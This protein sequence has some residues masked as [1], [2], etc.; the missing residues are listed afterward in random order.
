MGEFVTVKFG[1]RGKTYTRKDFRDMDDYDLFCKVIVFADCM[2]WKDGDSRTD[3]MNMLCIASSCI[4]ER[5]NPKANEEAETT[6]LDDDRQRVLA[7]ILAEQAYLD[8]EKAVKVANRET[9]KTHVRMVEGKDL[10]G[11]RE[12]DRIFKDLK[13]SFKR[14]RAAFINVRNF[15]KGT[16]D[17]YTSGRMEKAA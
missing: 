15:L 17:D 9:D 13:G 4:K 2:P 1:R 8:A 6:V 11:L 14:S 16:I 3:V 5:M 10:K 7:A 12:L